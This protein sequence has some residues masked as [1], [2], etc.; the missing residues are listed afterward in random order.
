MP[1]TEFEP[2]IP[3]GKQLQTHSLDRSAAGI[4]NCEIEYKTEIE[5]ILADMHKNP[6]VLRI[7]VKQQVKLRLPLSVCVSN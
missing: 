6:S 2:A 1:P 7:D 3:A 5:D 4:G